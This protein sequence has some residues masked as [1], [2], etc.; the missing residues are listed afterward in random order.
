LAGTHLKDKCE[1]GI[2]P[3]EDD[4]VNLRIMSIR[5]HWWQVRESRIVKLFL[6]M[7]SR[8]SLSALQG[9]GIVTQN[10]SFLHT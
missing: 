9:S 5:C 4:S 6:N 7:D 2:G 10:P 3:C 1:S 8:S